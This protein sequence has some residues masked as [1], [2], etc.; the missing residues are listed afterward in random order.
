[1][2]SLYYLCVYTSFVVEVLNASRTKTNTYISL[3]PRPCAVA[4]RKEVLQDSSLN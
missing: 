3:Y 1:M 4:A 2:L